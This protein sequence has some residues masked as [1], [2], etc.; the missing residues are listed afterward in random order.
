M[1]RIDPLDPIDRSEPSERIDHSEDVA[2]FTG[3]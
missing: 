2:W 3:P 1:L